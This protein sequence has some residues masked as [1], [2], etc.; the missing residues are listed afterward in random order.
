MINDELG[1]MKGSNRG[2]F[3]SGRLSMRCEQSNVINFC[4]KGRME[5]V[6]YSVS[7][8]SE[9]QHP[10]ELTLRRL[11]PGKAERIS[12]TS[13]ALLRRKLEKVYIG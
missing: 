11:N 4:R 8:I 7:N 13:S 1:M 9:Q 12:F 3:E 6:G 2:I 10:S 5:Q